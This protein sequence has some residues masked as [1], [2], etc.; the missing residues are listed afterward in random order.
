MDGHYQQGVLQLSLHAWHRFDRAARVSDI[1]ALHVDLDNRLVHL[2]AHERL[3]S[4]ATPILIGFT[5]VAITLVGS[6][7]LGG[8]VPNML[9]TFGLSVVGIGSWHR[10]PAVAIGSACGGLAAALLDVLLFGRRFWHG[11]LSSSP[12]HEA[13]R[14]DDGRMPD[15]EGDNSSDASSCD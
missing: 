9:R 2:W 10:F 13:E 3:M 7:M 12:R 11:L 4:M 1:I 6:E 8:E 15:V 14:G 5:Y